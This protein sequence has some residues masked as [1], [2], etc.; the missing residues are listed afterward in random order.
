MKHAILFLLVVIGILACHQDQKILIDAKYIDNA[1]KTD[2]SSNYE[3]SVQQDLVF[4]KK[5][6]DSDSEG[7]TNF[8]KYAS[9][10]VSRFRLYGDISDLKQAESIISRINN[11]THNNESGNL[12][13]LGH[14]VSLQHRFSE[15]DTMLT[16]ALKNGDNKYESMLMKYDVAFE[17]GRISE[18]KRLLT[19]IEKPHEY[20]YYF[21]LAKMQH[22]DGNMDKAIESMQTAADLSNGNVYLK[23]AALSNLADLQMHIGAFEEAANNYKTSYEIDHSDL[24]SLKGMAL[25]A[26]FHDKNYALAES[27]L[28]YIADK[29]CSPDVYFNLSQLYQLTGNKTLEKEYATQFAEIASQPVYGN[30]YNKYLIQLY[31]GI[32]NNPKA[33]LEVANNE[34]K[35]RNTPQ[36]NSWYAWALYQNNQA[37]LAMQVY[38]KHVSEQPLEG[39]ELYYMGKL[40]K[41]ENKSI[42]ANAFFKAAYKNRFELAPNY[43]SDLEKL[44]NS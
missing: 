37:A 36:T 17:L 33:I 19:F 30:M 25:V 39:L 10:L 44:V 2:R 4:W 16:K 14:V 22:Y 26:A 31:D 5:R 18:A 35:N 3:K 29:T 40:M 12:R 41:A 24:H 34:I 7:T 15:T 28:K 43:K 1:L 23:Q 38:K 42:N 32:L 11:E 9:S 8:K 21:R 13:T 27:V 20:A 6:V